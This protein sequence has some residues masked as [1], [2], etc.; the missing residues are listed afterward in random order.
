LETTLRVWERDEILDVL[1]KES[2]RRLEMTPQQMVD[3]YREGSLDDPGM[4][5]D[6]IALA[7]LLP[8]DDPLFVAP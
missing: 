5:S 4:V 1:G 8:N 3:A 7:F 6:L 2:W